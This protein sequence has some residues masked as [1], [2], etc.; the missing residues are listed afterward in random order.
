MADRSTH[1]ILDR[2]ALAILSVALFGVVTGPARMSPA[3][4]AERVSKPPP[5]VSVPASSAPDIQR[6]TG[7]A[8]EQSPARTVLPRTGRIR[9]PVL[10]ID[11]HLIPLGLLLD[12]S[13]DVPND[14]ALAGWYSQGPF[15]GEPGPAVVVGHVDWTSGPAVFYRLRDLRPGDL[16][17][18]RRTGGTR[19]RFVVTSLQW[20]AKTAF[21]TRR[22]YGAVRGPALRLITCGGAFDW[23]SGHYVDNLVVFAVPRI[24]A[25]SRGVRRLLI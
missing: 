4:H 13:L 15:P 3:A 2:M 17:V 1:R 18:V 19:A 14:P 16:I 12:G 20:F 7:R 22:I 8:L 10:G 23:S 6:R 9:I 5:K 21:P 11:A 25:S 24:D